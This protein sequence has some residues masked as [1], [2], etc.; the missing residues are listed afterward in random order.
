MPRR[1]AAIIQADVA[2]VLRAVHQAKAKMRVEVY[3]DGRI[4]IVPD[5]GL[6]TLSVVAAPA[7]EATREIVL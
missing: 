5:D 3:P 4:V 6:Q 7:D 1:P 2:R